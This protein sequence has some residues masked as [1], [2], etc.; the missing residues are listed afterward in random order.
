M[1]RIFNLFLYGGFRL[2]DFEFFGLLRSVLTGEHMMLFVGADGGACLA[3]RAVFGT[4]MELGN[5]L[6]WFC[7]F[8]TVSQF[9]RSWLATGLADMKCR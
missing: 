2:L 1:T 7:F 9:P 3:D 4:P 5:C 8:P 6:R